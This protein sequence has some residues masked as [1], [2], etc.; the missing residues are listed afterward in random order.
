M[1]SKLDSAVCAA[2]I[3]TGLAKARRYQRNSERFREEQPFSGLSEMHWK[4]MRK[5]LFDV[6]DAMWLTGNHL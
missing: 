3:S 4:A 2:V 1:T 6:V 5:H